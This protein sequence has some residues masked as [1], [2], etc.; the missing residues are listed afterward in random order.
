MKKEPIGVFMNMAYAVIVVYALIEAFKSLPFKEALIS[1]L[2]FVAT[3][4]F[5]LKCRIRIW[6]YVREKNNEFLKQEKIKRKK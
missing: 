2:L 1:S 6:D 5:F 3:V 4:I